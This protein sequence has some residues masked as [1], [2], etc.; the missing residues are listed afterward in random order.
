MKKTKLIEGWGVN[1]VDYPVHKVEKVNGKKKIVWTC[2]YYVDWVQILCRSLSKNF[3]HNNPTYIDCTV[4]TEWK[5]LSNF[6]KW[7]DSQ[8]NRGWEN[9]QLDKDFLIEGNKHYSPDTCVYIQQGLN[10]F[11]GSSAKSRGSYM[12]GVSAIP[13]SK[14][15]PYQAQC[16]NPFTLQKEYLGY[17]QLN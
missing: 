1:D 5:Y 6:I 8:P 15:N 17:F 9:C 4:C 2:P 10:L 14:V 11:I 16:S 3:Q 13:R 7:V 12:L